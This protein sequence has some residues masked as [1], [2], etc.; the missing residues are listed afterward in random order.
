MNAHSSKMTFFEHVNELRNRILVSILFIFVFSILSYFYSSDI[1]D[2][3]LDPVK[4]NET[5]NFQVLK[6][7]SLFFV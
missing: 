6:I 1:L 7:T 3:L 5:I 2:F 4:N